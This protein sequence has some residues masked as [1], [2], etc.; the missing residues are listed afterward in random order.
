VGG[1]ASGVA[2]S[3]RGGTGW[4]TVDAL[5]EAER[6]EITVMARK[7]FHRPVELGEFE[8]PQKGAASNFQMSFLEY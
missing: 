7:L 4:E 2:V 3:F 8:S 5:K 6:M 1:I